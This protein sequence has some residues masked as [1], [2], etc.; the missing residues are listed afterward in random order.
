MGM[1]E[2]LLGQAPGNPSLS[3]TQSPI[4]QMA[5][6]QYIQGTAQPYQPPQ[7][8]PNAPISPM[9][10]A[11]DV[12]GRVL[13]S[14]LQI[15]QKERVADVAKAQSLTNLIQLGYPPEMVFQDKKAVKA[16][17]KVYNTQL[18]R[19]AHGEAV[20][21]PET[22]AQKIRGMLSNQLNQA[23]TPGQ[24]IQMM[25]RLGI[26]QPT[27]QEQ[28]GGQVQVKQAGAQF[29]LAKDYGKAIQNYAKDYEPATA[30]KLAQWETANAAKMLGMQ[31][32]E[33][34]LT[35]P[36]I[37]QELKG[38]EQKLAWNMAEGIMKQ[39]PRVDPQTA[40]T[41]GSLMVKGQLKPDTF[42]KMIKG[43]WNQSFAVQQGALNLMKDQKTIQKMDVDMQK[44]FQE[45]G[46][47]E[48]GR[49]VPATAVDPKA[50]PK[51]KI[52]TNYAKAFVGLQQ[53]IAQ[54]N[55]LKQNFE[56]DKF[57]IAFQI[58]NTKKATNEMKNKA[59]ND[60]NAL[61]G[62]QRSAPMWREIFRAMGLTIVNDTSWELKSPGTTDRN[63]TQ[64][65]VNSGKR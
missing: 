23:Q 2:D 29:D 48:E 58:L 11:G 51:E 17:E 54:V 8:N 3:P 53:D 16:F 65:I 46:I 13:N 50:D 44:T 34:W 41:I 10:A 42:S 36:D 27:L 15:K 56:Q 1:L 38:D 30:Q 49:Y 21:P 52:P 25:Q 22:P 6:Q 18:P 35:P 24:Q 62:L 31:V 40:N 64:S 4:N 60:I 20:I 26:M 47:A 57:K 7:I 32:P 14:W 63:N 61:F 39:D 55:V 28:I 12:V 19:D 37:G 9:D 33:A 45:M 5:L 43:G 59:L